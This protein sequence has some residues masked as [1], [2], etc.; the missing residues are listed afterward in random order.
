MVKYLMEKICALD[1]LLSTWV[2]VLLAVSSMLMN[3]QGILI[4]ILY[5]YAH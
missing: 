2:I 5:I 4:C 3:Q 1:K